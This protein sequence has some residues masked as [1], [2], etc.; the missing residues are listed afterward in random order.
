MSDLPP[1]YALPRYARSSGKIKLKVTGTGVSATLATGTSSHGETGTPKLS[2]D[3]AT[4]SNSLT[5]R[6]PAAG[7]VA[8]TKS[9]VRALDSLPQTSS[10]STALSAPLSVPASTPAPVP[11]STTSAL[12]ATPSTAAAPPAVPKMAAP[13]P[14][15]AVQPFPSTQYTHYPNAAYRQT[16]QSVATP[17]P[18]TSA[19]TPPVQH[20]TAHSVSRS[21]VPSLTGHRPLSQ[22]LILTKPRGRPF[23]LDH[24]DGVKSWAI[25]L[26]QGEGSLLVADVKFL[27]EDDRDSSDEEARGEEI[28]EPTLKK[29]GRGRTTKNS[30]AKAKSTLVKEHT[31][32]K[33]STPTQE[34][35]QIVLN[36]TSV[37]A[38]CGESGWEM[39]LQIG[40]NVLEVGEKG[41]YVWK[42]YLE[43][44]STV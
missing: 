10:T 33:V 26:G 1:P 36:G 16:T 19:A 11:A 18:S 15:V 42:V 35:V 8:A 31:S 21:P 44:P 13:S 38:K 39:E 14:K 5:F 27:G 6:L 4:T 2:Q 20:H 22:I 43:K 34:D 25:R 41:G 23:W 30:K 29:R 28:E 7:S 3:Q 40:S 24:R 9:P 12:T 17:Q 32:K 37:T